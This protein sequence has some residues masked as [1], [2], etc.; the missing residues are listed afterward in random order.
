ME[1]SGAE[2]QRDQQKQGD[3]SE[4]KDEARR[5]EEQDERGEQDQRDEARA[6]EEQD[7]R[8]EQDQK[9]EAR[10]QEE[11]DEQAESRDEDEDEGEE[12]ESD[13]DEEDEDS[14][15]FISLKR[16]NWGEFM[17]MLAALGL[18]ATLHL[19]WFSTSAKN[20]NSIITSAGVGP[21]ETATA[22]QTFP[23]L[24]WL[25][26]AACA[27]PFVLTWIV[28]CGHSLSWKPGEVTM[29]AGMTAFV[30]ILCNG[31]VLGKPEP[32]IDISLSWGYPLALLS[33]AAMMAGGF[34][35]QALHQD[36][37]QPPGVF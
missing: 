11:Q 2:R 9:D 12:P 21:G 1:A 4:E 26:V 16:L 10:A 14:G 3:G 34:L 15:P 19:P 22:W 27:A 36:A 6:K 23:I 30:L 29:L 24:K 7:E 28:A 5:Q 17:G 20:E 25:L 18:F 31:L 8:G 32:G 13:S 35:R 33:A 37:K